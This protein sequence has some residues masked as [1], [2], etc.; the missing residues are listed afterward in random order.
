MPVIASNPL[1]MSNATLSVLADDYAAACSS[2][3]VTPA[4]TSVTFKGLKPT[5]VA[6]FAG[7]PTWTLDIVHAQDLA[8]ATSLQNYLL[9][10]QGQTKSFIFEPIAGG[11]KVTVTAMIV[12]GEIGGAV[13]TVATSTV[14]LPVIGVPVLS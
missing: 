5:A 10:N 7:N 13:E 2:I 8:T 6:T 9:A 1:F 11:K 3:T 14:S 4:V 12:P